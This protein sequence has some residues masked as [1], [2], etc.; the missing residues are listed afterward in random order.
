MLVVAQWQGIIGR[1]FALLS[2]LLVHCLTDRAVCTIRADNNVAR[3]KATGVQLFRKI[4]AKK[5]RLELTGASICVL[6]L[7]SP[8]M[9]MFERAAPNKQQ[10]YVR[11]PDKS[12]EHPQGGRNE[13]QR[14]SKII[15][16]KSRK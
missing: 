12:D 2:Q 16:T 14:M 5:I 10:I 4:T 11:Y 1:K 13:E 6:L 15:D 3:I 9:G 7:F 8:W